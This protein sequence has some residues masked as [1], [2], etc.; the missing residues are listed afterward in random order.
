[1]SPTTTVEG[2]AERLA[3]ENVGALVVVEAHKAGSIVLDDIVNSLPRSAKR[4][5]R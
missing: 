3:A 4:S 5:M 2:A 1:V